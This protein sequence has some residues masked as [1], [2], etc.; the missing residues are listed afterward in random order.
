MPLPKEIFPGSD[1]LDDINSQ[2][3]IV[4]GN[5][6]HYSFNHGGNLVI[7]QKLRI[8]EGHS[9][10]KHAH[11]VNQIGSSERGEKGSNRLL[12][13]RL[14]IGEFGIPL[15]AGDITRQPVKVG[16]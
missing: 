8:T 5:A 15:R 3:L 2:C 11:S 14:G 6:L 1:L 10:L 4:N 9:K 13:A 12:V 16:E 7:N